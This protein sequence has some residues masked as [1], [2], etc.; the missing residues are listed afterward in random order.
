M[1]DPRPARPLLVAVLT[2][3]HFWA[4]LA[5]LALGLALLVFLH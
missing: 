1:P 2:D 4:P 3:A 5:V